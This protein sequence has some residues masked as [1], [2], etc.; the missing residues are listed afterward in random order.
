MIE[1][2]EYADWWRRNK[3]RVV[4]FCRMEVKNGGGGESE[5]EYDC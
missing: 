1:C 2:V 5:V 3:R 4:M